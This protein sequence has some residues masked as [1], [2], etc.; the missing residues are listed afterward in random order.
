MKGHKFH[1]RR[2]LKENRGKIK[3]LEALII[4]KLLRIRS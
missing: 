1:V 2:K 3:K 4:K